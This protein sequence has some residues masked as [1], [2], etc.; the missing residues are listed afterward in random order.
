[1]LAT[2]SQI[3]S[4][5]HGLRLRFQELEDFAAGLEQTVNA[6]II[7]LTTEHTPPSLPVQNGYHVPCIIIEAID[8]SLWTVSSNED[9]VIRSVL[10]HFERTTVVVADQ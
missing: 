3:N 6:V 1:M 7:G 9:V 2:E 5:P 4:N 8:S 10:E